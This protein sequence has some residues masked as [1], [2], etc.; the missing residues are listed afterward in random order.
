MRGWVVPRL[1]Y[2]CIVNRDHAGIVR[3]VFL[4]S[5]YTAS[6]DL[7]TM[8]GRVGNCAC[9]NWSSKISSASNGNASFLTVGGIIRLGIF[10]SGTRCVCVRASSAVI[11]DCLL[12]LLLAAHWGAGLMIISWSSVEIVR[13]AF[14][15]V[16][17]YTGDATKETPYVLFWLRYS[18]FWLLYPSGITGELAVFLTAASDPRFTT[19]A[20]GLYTFYARVLPAIYFF[21]SPFMIYNMIL[22]RKSAMKKRFAKPPPPPRGLCWPVDQRGER[23]STEVN[24][25]IMAAAVGATSATKAA[26]ILGCKNWRFG[27][28]RHLL[29]L[30][31]EQCA[32]AEAALAVA[33]AGFFKAYELFEFVAPD[34]TAVSFDAAMKAA[35]KETFFTHVIQGTGE[36][37]GDKMLQVPYKGQNLSGNALKEQVDRWVSYG[38]IEPSAGDAIKKAVDHPEWISDQTLKGRYFVLLGA[39]SAMGPLLVLMSLGAHV[40][41]VDLD[42]PMIWSRLISIARSSPGGSMTIP[43]KVDPTSIFTPGS[44]ASSQ[45]VLD[46]MCENAGC[47]LFTDTPRIRNWLLTLYPGMPLTIGS[48]AYLD[49]ALHVQVS[50]AMDAI[51]RD[52]TE[53][54][55][56]C[57]L[58]YLCT[59]TDLHLCP[60]EAYDAAQSNYNEYSKKIFCKFCL[61]SNVVSN[62]TSPLIRAFEI[63]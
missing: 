42:R 29:G 17:I 27:Y 44:D 3:F 50:L 51:C 35:S 22:N 40:I 12:I 31:Q 28:V 16:A 32:S 26:A 60:K 49:G 46:K 21:G 48:Y 19:L 7:C 24:K 6:F 20:N 9:S 47:N 11:V 10:A 52:L 14:Y 34:G 56:N 37:S 5:D 39:G 1:V 54:R 55:S 25:A 41:A 18:L 57:S 8:H 62:D 59:P 23:S 30:V 36:R 13:Y 2:E 53:K 33:E 45:A 38:T 61:P 4:G 15:V 43:L 63:R 58:A